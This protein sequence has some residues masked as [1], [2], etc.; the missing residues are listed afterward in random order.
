MT[1]A[2][3]PLPVRLRRV[4]VGLR[5]AA[6]L[7]GL[8]AAAALGLGLV[9]PRASASCAGPQVVLE[10]DGAVVTPRRVGQGEAERLRY[11]VADDQPL[12]V[13]ASNL[14][15]GC[16]DTP[17][18][19]GGCGRPVADPEPPVEPMEDVA[20]VLTQEDR[21][22]TLAVA[23]TVGADLTARFDLELPPALRPGPATLALVDGR[24]QSG[25]D[26]ELDIH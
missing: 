21:S 17:S 19:V 5:R 24:E 2:V 9:A 7:A 18:T 12:R 15:T 25:T 14:T 1:G 23:D 20:L 4:P 10:Q 26:L 8:I 22:W 13:D 16:R 3:P 11:D 6:A